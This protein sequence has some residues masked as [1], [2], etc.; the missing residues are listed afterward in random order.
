[1]EG[2]EPADG[3]DDLDDEDAPEIDDDREEAA[4]SVT[5][6]ISGLSL[7]THHGVTTPSARSAS[8]W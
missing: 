4:E 6:E 5:V 1:M 7:Y 8:V 2:E 3:G